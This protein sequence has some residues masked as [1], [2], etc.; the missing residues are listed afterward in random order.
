MNPM[1]EAPF[2]TVM[3]PVRNEAASIER[4]LRR[5]AEQ[6]YDASRF[7]VI[8]ADGCSTDDTVPIVQ[9]VQAEFPNIRL[10]HNPKRWSSAARNLCVQHGRGDYFV[11]VDGHCDLPDPLYLRHV[12]SAFERSGAD[13][14]GRPQPLE[15]D[16]ATPVQQ[17]IATARRCWL[18]HNP[19]SFIYSAEER[20]VA[21]S[22]VAVAYRREVFERIGLFDERFDA[23]ED[24]EFN[25][26]IDCAGMTCFFTPRI[27]VPYH[28][29]GTMRGLVYQMTRYG[30]GRLRLARKHPHS[31]SLPAVAPMLFCLGLLM[32]GLLGIWVPL[33][34]M[35]FCLGILGYAAIITLAS[36][37]LLPRPGK[38][39]SKC[40][41]PFVFVAVHVG[42]AWGTTTELVERIVRMKP[43][44]IPADSTVTRIRPVAPNLSLHNRAA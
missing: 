11:L 40:C 27:A 33:F 23:C 18:G 36:L 32:S 6:D 34:A 8:V 26:R 38:L 39:L 10:L 19:S 16:S 14:L 41:L 21:A 9:R 5:L 29:R 28:P 2:I 12:A 7:E 44:R 35:L 31:L 17:A 42:F 43:Q 4:V 25:T 3:L 15:I 37:T 24:V 30:R 22:S 13:C 1:P 20:F